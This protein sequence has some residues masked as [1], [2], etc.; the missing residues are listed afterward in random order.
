[1]EEIKENVKEAIKIYNKMANRID[2]RK[3]E[4]A[5]SL[6][7]EEMH[8]QKPELE[9]YKSSK[10]Y[11][12]YIEKP[13]KQMYFYDNKVKFKEYGYSAR[14]EAKNGS[15][16]HFCLALCGYSKERIIEIIENHIIQDNLE[17]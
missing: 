1:M 10:K 17:E 15:S 3:F 13:Y 2:V 9:Y 7:L 11:D 6:I 14:G 16:I 12:Y 4:K 5:R 8:N